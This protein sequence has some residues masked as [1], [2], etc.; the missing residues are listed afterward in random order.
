LRLDNGQLA[1]CGLVRTARLL[2]D[3][4]VYVRQSVFSA[5]V[6]NDKGV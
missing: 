2:F 5:A 6:E 1:G 3:G 4:H